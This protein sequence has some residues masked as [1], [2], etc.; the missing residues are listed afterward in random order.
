MAERGT[1]KKNGPGAKGKE[2]DGMMEGGIWRRMEVAKR[3]EAGLKA[4][5]AGTR[6]R[7][8]GEGLC[9]NEARER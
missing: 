4:S 6:Q 7:G 9:L 5:D 1:R 2:N 8:S 3:R